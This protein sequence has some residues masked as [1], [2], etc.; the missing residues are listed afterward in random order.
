[1]RTTGSRAP[2][3]D[4]PLVVKVR[5]SAAGAEPSYDVAERITSMFGQYHM[6]CVGE[7][8]CLS[9]DG[10]QVVLIVGEA[11]VIE[12][13]PAPSAEAGPEAWR[14]VVRPSKGDPDEYT[15]ETFDEAAD[16]AAKSAYHYGVYMAGDA[17]KPGE[18]GAREDAG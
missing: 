1:M 15:R 18:E 17:P 13:S 8:I 11:A 6:R 14:V 3:A 5:A 16:E 4:N 10:P 7:E 9:E 2:T 12:M